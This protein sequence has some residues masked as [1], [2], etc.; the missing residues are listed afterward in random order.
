MCGKSENHKLFTHLQVQSDV[1]VSMTKPNDPVSPEPAPN[2]HPAMADEGDIASTF[3]AVMLM[4]R[5]RIWMILAIV[6]LGT[7]LAGFVGHS[8]TP[9]YTAQA[10]VMIEPKENRIV[11]VEAVAAGLSGDITA[12]E[13]QVKLLSS[14]E[15]LARLADR[16]YGPEQLLA[17][18]EETGPGEEEPEQGPLAK[19]VAMIP[20]DLLIATGL[21]HEP[22]MLDAEAEAFLLREKRVERIADRLKVK[23]EGRSFVLSIN[24]TSPNPQEAARIANTL[25]DLY[26]DEQVRDKLTTTKRASGWLEIRLAELKQELEDAEAAAERYR[27]EHRLLESRGLQM[28][29]QQVGELTNLLV[30][31]RAARSEKETRLRYI[32]SM[33]SKGERLESVTEVLESPYLANL[34]QQESALLKEEAELLTQFGDRHP[35]VQNLAAEKKKIGEKI[36]RETKRLVDNIANEI[37]VLSAKEKSVQ[38]DIN[39]LIKQ[40]D[41]AGQAEVELRQLERQAEASRKIYEDF[42]YRYKETKEQQEIVQPNARVIARA[43]PPI[44]PSSI[45]PS[46]ILLVGLVGSSVAGISLA[47]LTERLDN[48]VRSGKQIESEFGLP[49]LGLVPYLRGMARKYERR[50]HRY[51]LDKPLSTYAETIRSVHTALRLSNVDQP[52]KVV[53]VTSSVPGEGKTT[54]ATSLAALLA[55]TGHRTLLLDLDLRHPSVHREITLP[56]DDAFFRYMMGEADVAELIHHDEVSGVDVIG[57]CK[58]AHNPAAIVASQR[59]SDLMRELR[60][61]YDYIVVDST[62]VLGVSDSKVTTELVDTVLFVVRWEKTTRDTAIDALKELV[63]L[64]IN[65]GGVVLTQVDVVRHARYGYGGIDNYYHKYN[66]YYQN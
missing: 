54:F 39:N 26:I 38:A 3:R 17:H 30:S 5:R 48:G 65:V 43:K 57:V 59:L 41:V 11:D 14:R 15:Y 49:C 2:Y 9:T 44:E 63:E 55:Q 25:A 18:G 45:P 7:G 33:Q 4:I 62:P 40:S 24:Y 46:L 34:W 66:K 35:R 13:T 32:R 20:E 10:M 6:V 1:G 50:P 61:A 37:S 36:E 42:L 8:R 22:Q 28:S 51:L 56:N 23:Q 16:L 12:I 31:T 60:S 21:A 52:P 19:L 29:S 47:W 27:S 53:Q 58:P 64:N